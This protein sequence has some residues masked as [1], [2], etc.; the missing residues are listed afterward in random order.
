MANVIKIKKSSEG[1]VIPTGLTFGELA[2]NIKDRKLFFLNDLG[3]LQSFDLFSTPVKQD[4]AMLIQQLVI[5]ISN[6]TNLVNIIGNT[7][8]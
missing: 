4:N 3:V 8:R 5:N 7:W 2:I 1:G 6:Q